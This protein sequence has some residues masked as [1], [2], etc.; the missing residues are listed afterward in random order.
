MRKTA[1]LLTV[2]SLMACAAGISPMLTSRGLIYQQSDSYKS[3]GH[4]SQAKRR[5]LNRIRMSN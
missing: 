2:A 3:I 1:M 5:K 4:R